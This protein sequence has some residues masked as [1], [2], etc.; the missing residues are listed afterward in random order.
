MQPFHLNQ[1]VRIFECEAVGKITIV[2]LR[3]QHF[4][5]P[6]FSAFGRTKK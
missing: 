5:S 1:A 6:T 4:A 2:L 3:R